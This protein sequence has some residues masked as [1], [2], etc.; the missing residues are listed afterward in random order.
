M[1]THFVDILYTI[2]LKYNPEFS[3]DS[4][5]YHQ[6]RLRQP[7]KGAAGVAPAARAVARG[8]HLRRKASAGPGVHSRNGSGGVEKFVKKTAGEVLSTQKKVPKKCLQV[9][10]YG[11]WLKKEPD[12]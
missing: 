2:L 7:E 6:K 8:Q 12:A 10:F 1:S 4:C 3:Q 5:V 9:V 11:F